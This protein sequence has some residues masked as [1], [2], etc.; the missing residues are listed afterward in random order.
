MYCNLLINNVE[1]ITIDKI[2]ILIRF[3]NSIED[4]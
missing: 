4:D 2:Y 3:L 1:K